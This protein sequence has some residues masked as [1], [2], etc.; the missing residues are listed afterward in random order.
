MVECHA[1]AGRTS[2]AR[3]GRGRCYM[4]PKGAP[5]PAALIRFPRRRAYAG[6]PSDLRHAGP[7]LVTERAALW[8]VI[9]HGYGHEDDHARPGEVQSCT[10][11]SVQQQVQQPHRPATTNYDR[12]RLL[13]CLNDL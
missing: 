11:T 13:S 9:E 8:L 7:Q 2:S 10:G 12:H 3:A 5:C 6:L 1:A 4:T